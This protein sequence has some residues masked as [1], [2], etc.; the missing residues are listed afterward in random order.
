M[1]ALTTDSSTASSPDNVERAES[2]DSGLDAGT[3]FTLTIAT[4]LALLGTLAVTGS[5]LHDWLHRD[6][7][8]RGT[9]LPVTLLLLAGAI[10][11]LVCLSCRKRLHPVLDV[12]ALATATTV[13]YGIHWGMVPAVHPETAGWWI[14]HSL[15]VALLC[16]AL[17]ALPAVLGYC[18]VRSSGFDI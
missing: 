6:Q 17:L 4:A 9:A 12:P 18:F 8:L 3:A 15:L 1:T 14:W 11:W 2:A 7:G 13:C 16:V 5:Q 10:A